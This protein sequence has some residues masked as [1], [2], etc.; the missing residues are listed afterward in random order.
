M[1][2]ESEN[3]S[4]DA[5]TD[6]LN[7]STPAA[8][9][10]MMQQ[11]EACKAQA[12]D[13]LLLF[14]LGD[15]Y[16]AFEEDAHI[17]SRLLGLTLTKRQGVPM[18]GI[19]SVSC[20]SYVDK[21]VALGRRVAIAEQAQQPQ[22]TKGLVARN[23]VRVVT[24]GACLT[25][26]RLEE[27][28]SYYFAALMQ[29]G[30]RFGFA[31]LDPTTGEFRVS[32]LETLEELS[33]EILR[34]MPR[35][36][37]VAKQ[38]EAKYEAFFA[39]M[40]IR[41]SFAL[42]AIDN[43][44]FE[45]A[46]TYRFLLD[47][48]QLHS[49]DGLALKGYAAGVHAAG[50]LL[51]HVRDVLLLPIGHVHALKPYRTHDYLVID[52]HSQRHLE[53]AA[54]M[55]EG[56][57]PTLLKLLDKTLTPMGGRL[58]AQWL[59]QPLA[60]LAEITARHEA[61]EEWTLN[62]SLMKQLQ[63]LLERVRDLERLMGKIQTGLAVPRDYAAL[64]DACAPLKDVIA[65][66]QLLASRLLCQQ[67]EQMHSLSE[68][69]RLLSEALVDDP[70]LRLGEGKIFRQGY[71]QELDEWRRLG[72]N[73]QEWMLQY[74]TK[75]REET[76]IKTLKVSF[77]KLSGYHIE[78]S[79]GQ[80][81]KMPAHFMRR[82][83]LTNSQ[84]YITPELK[85]YE[86]KVLHAEERIAACESSL[87]AALRQ[88]VLI[89]CQPLLQTAR[90]IAVV[91]SLQS[92]SAVAISQGYVRPSMHEGKSLKIIDGRHPVIETLALGEKFVPNDT[93]L[94]GEEKRLW[95]IT[96]P[97]MAGKSTFLRQVALIV[98]LAQM[99]GFV[100]ARFAEIGIVDKLFTR[101]GASDDLASG[102]STFMVEMT[103][104]AHI[105]HSCTDR[106]LVILDEIGRGTSTYD[107]ISIAWAV[108]EHLLTTPGCQPKTLFATHYGELTELALS[109]TGAM[110]YHVAV[111]ECQDR[112]C[113]LRKI[114]PGVADKSY[115]I[116]VGALAG[117]PAAVLARAREILG[118]LEGVFHKAQG[119]QM[120][121]GKK[122]PPLRP[123][124]APKKADAPKEIQLT[125]FD[126]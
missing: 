61:V 23:I 10:P 18:A 76:G 118:T 21:L 28:V 123:P 57:R 92:L 72:A 117:L 80:A 107:G 70:P 65:L 8:R 50:A 68:L 119:F 11:W 19:P 111:Q 82:Q 55:H 17:L 31:F 14:R 93:Y 97:N 20:E 5:A 41:F 46:M 88:E 116:H 40:Q 112:I 95:I 122:L 34:F 56:K 39:Q 42:T 98:I 85:E 100:P 3:L 89:Y 106:S 6:I 45:P 44:H 114:V 96:G 91:D 27:K 36:M 7:A 99:G 104:T 94:D 48:F 30:Q 126:K 125:F 87:F 53:L 108:A 62:Q 9:S 2:G 15:F 81:E 1:H 90:A 33:S 22:A 38:F 13:A 47:H 115:G 121:L 69:V 79:I 67:R 4:E 54:S 86:E 32:E 105:L 74:Q 84:R 49:L 101:I 37:L 29:I 64:R 83:T 58:L 73:S 63:G 102:Q 24:P 43:W 12:G 109:Q 103:E 78:V 75:L 16:E 71:N 60:A 35:E 25:S 51:K 124:K 120:S 113:F 26:T 66:M 59:K 52:A 77:S 110:N